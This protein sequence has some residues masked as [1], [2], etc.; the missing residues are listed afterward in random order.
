MLVLSRKKGEAIRLADDIEVT[1]S[2]ISGNRVRLAISAPH[3]VSIRRSE[4]YAPSFPAYVDN[5]DHLADPCSNQQRNRCRRASIGTFPVSA[6]V[7]FVSVCERSESSVQCDN[8][9]RNI[10]ETCRGSTCRT[11]VTSNQD[12]DPAGLQ[13]RSIRHHLLERRPW[14]AIRWHSR[15][16][17]EKASCPNCRESARL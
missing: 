2:Q 7:A 6:G 12:F 17:Y 5:Y 4:L 16:V 11:A 8:P 13:S 1:V 3:H 15:R 10:C 14:P 9:A